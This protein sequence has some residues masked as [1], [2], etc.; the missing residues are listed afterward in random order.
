MGSYTA[1]EGIRKA[2]VAAVDNEPSIEQAVNVNHLLEVNHL[3][4]SENT[5]LQQNNHLL[6]VLLG[7]RE[8]QLQESGQ[9]ELKHELDE[10]REL[11]HRL[12]L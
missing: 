12:Q 1:A 4:R 8:R 5:S 9:L 11:L 10:L 2:R 7:E 6:R 3:L